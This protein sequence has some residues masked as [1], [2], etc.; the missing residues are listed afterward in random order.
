MSFGVQVMLMIDSASSTTGKSFI[1]GDMR[2]HDKIKVEAEE[3]GGWSPSMM[4]DR[5]VLLILPGRGSGTSRG[6]S[7][8][9]ITTM[10]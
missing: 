3:I 10:D 6:M 2:V 8:R 4:R 5:S 9:S 1:L 7:C